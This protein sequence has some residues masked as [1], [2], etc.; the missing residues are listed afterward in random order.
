MKA[1]DEKQAVD[2]V[3]E[4]I[5]DLF[6][7]PLVQIR[8]VGD[9]ERFDYNIS[10]DG[11]RFVAEY[12]THA[13]TA[14]VSAAIDGLKN[15]VE[16]RSDVVPLLVVP[17]MGEVGRQ[18][19]NEA[20]VS[21]ID[22]SGNAKIVV[23]GV[24]IWIEGRPNKFIERGRPPNVFAPKSSR[25]A[26]QLLLQPFSYQLQAELARE[27]KLGDG[28]V[29]KIVR[30]LRKEG[31]V[32]QDEQ[33]AV[34][35]RDPNLLLDGW[36][37]VYDF[38]RHRIIRG[39]VAA[40]TGE[41]LLRKLVGKLEQRKVMYAA[42]GLSAAWLYCNFAAFRLASIY[43]SS[44]PTKKLLREIEFNE[45]PRGANVW[46]ILPDDDG[47]FHG[48]NEQAEVRCVSPLQTYLDLKGHPE[49]AKDAAVELRR[50]HLSWGSHD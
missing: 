12:K 19:C 31:Y 46:L 30:R 40:R 42:T 25:I 49:R 11:L 48:C 13:S 14:A 4:L 27:T 5:T 1:P 37:E 22:L 41:E 33:G 36:H 17:Y 50:E 3:R 21:W 15:I 24:R 35:P 26:R 7:G 39:H 9:R 45:E 23:P 34:R 47:V 29:S 6:G 38:S 43:L 28:Y 16:G 20:T 18:L 8:H 44:M 32:D 2:T 10:I